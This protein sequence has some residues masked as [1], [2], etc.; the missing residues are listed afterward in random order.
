MHNPL[1]DIAGGEDGVADS[2]ASSH[3]EM[4]D[5]SAFGNQKAA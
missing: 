1:T 2:L 5:N 3:S 4:W